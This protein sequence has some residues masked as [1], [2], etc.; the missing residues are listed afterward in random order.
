MVNQVELQK[1]IPQKTS[2]KF[3]EHLV[4]TPAIRFRLDTELD[5]IKTDTA[6]APIERL[7]LFY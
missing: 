6:K 3:A 4:T 2:I 7:A 5:K 1:K